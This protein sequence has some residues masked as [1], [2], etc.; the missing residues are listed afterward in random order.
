MLILFVRR[1]IGVVK[2]V[3]N[4]FYSRTADD[5]AG[6]RRLALPSRSEIAIHQGGTASP[7]ALPNQS[8]KGA[9]YEDGS[10]TSANREA[11]SFPYKSRKAPSPLGE[12]NSF[13]VSL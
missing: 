2:G 9:Q 1:C 6:L 12:A 11:N 5:I 8:A 10:K 4:K 3:R 13:P 7:R